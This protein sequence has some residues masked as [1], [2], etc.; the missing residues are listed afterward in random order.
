MPDPLAK[1]RRYNPKPLE[2]A[3]LVIVLSCLVLLAA[4][5]IGLLAR[6]ESDRANSSAYRGST[7]SRNL[8]EYAISVVMAQISSATK[9]DP[10]LAWASQPGAIRTYSAT[11]TDLVNIYKLY[12]SP[13]MV[14][15]TFP[16]DDTDF[17]G[18]ADNPALYTDLNAPVVTGSGANTRTNYPI[19]DPRASPA[20]RGFEIRRAPD[21][22]TLQPAPMPVTW[23]YVL[24]D[25]S[26]AAPTDDGNGNSVTVSAS[27]TN[28][29]VG[30]IAFWTDDDT[31]KVNINTASGA[32]WEYTNASFDVS[33]SLTPSTMMPANFWDTPIIGSRQDV[34]LAMSQPWA[35]EY[36]RFPGHPATVS[37]SAVFPNLTTNQIMDIAPRI[38]YQGG[39]SRWGSVLNPGA[40]RL[41]DDAARL[42]ANVDELLFATNR[43][44]SGTNPMTQQQLDQGRFFLT[45]SSRSPDVTLFNTPRLLIWPVDTAANKQ[46]P[47]DKLIA[48]CGTV[49]THSYYFQRTDAYSPTRDYNQPRNQTLLAYLRRMTTQA[50]P[51]FGGAS[52]ILGKYNASAPGESEQITTQ[53][54]DYIRCIN[55][56]DTSMN[57]P[58]N[59]VAQNAANYY[60]TNGLVVPTAG[61]N[62]TRGF[63]RFPMVS[64]VGLIFWYNAAGAGTTN[65]LCSRLLLETFIPGQGYPR[66][67]PPVPNFSIEVSGLT[68]G[69]GFQWGSD[70]ASMTNIFPSDSATY[71]S[72]VAFLASR[73]YGGRQSIS[74]LSGGAISAASPL[75][76]TSA[77]AT[78]DLTGGNITIRIIYGGHTIQ[79]INNISLPSVAGLPLP[80]TT[81]I[82]NNNGTSTICDGPQA[83]TDTSIRA[84]ASANVL[85]LPN[86][87]VR[88]VQVASGD[89]RMVAAGSNPLNGAAY[90][91]N[92]LNYFDTSTNSQTK[93]HSFLQAG[94]FPYQGSTMLAGGYYSPS[95]TNTFSADTARQVWVNGD[96]ITTG[97]TASGDFDN[98]YGEAGDGPYIGFADEGIQVNT[99]YENS[100]IPYLAQGSQTAVVGPGLYS[101]NR[102]VPSAGILGSLPTGVLANRP[103]QTLLFRPV[104][105]TV[106]GHPGAD[107]PPDYL[108]LDLFNMP[109]VEPYAIS[110]PL[111]TAGRVNMNYQILPFTYIQR[112]TAVQAALHTEWMTAIRSALA[113]NPASVASRT[114]KTAVL[115]T[116]TANNSRYPLNLT[117]TLKGFENRFAANDLFR[118][119]AEICSIPLVPTGSTWDA[120]NNG[121]FWSTNTLTGDNSKERAYAR[122]FPKLTTKSNTYTVHYRVEVLKK[123]PNSNAAT[124]IEGQDKVISTHRGS[125]TI[126]RYVTPG[127]PA[128]PDYASMATIPPTGTTALPNFYKF[129]VVGELQFNP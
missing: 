73:H 92:H 107:N 13:T 4:L 119:A 77:P 61:I 53:I 64:K 42:Y 89:F 68:S 120:V 103:W 99:T 10:T 69:G 35:G 90:F 127:D 88:S 28:P 87:V 39:G 30:R 55:L 12:S 81:T 101:P 44:V 24:E 128:M 16:S 115:T 49:G 40:A 22:T 108:L 102:L 83:W 109:V 76:S 45:A 17:T 59:T 71:K 85:I 46:T 117:E 105:L 66:I 129:R 70:A 58:T 18:W 11:G 15:D 104:A 112:S 36:Q 78:F 82:T 79:T 31:S 43:S 124:W 56:Q 32:P 84:R 106:A 125:T 86:D 51:G 48:F 98:G 20:V 126:E 122:I 116:G 114:R 5:V 6:V 34:N 65:T 3:A 95:D 72:Q 80:R 94:G 123:K 110:E 121:T 2:G 14:T 91:T 113:T 38:N 50:V 93:A 100:M 25:G 27:P 21:A 26:L 67:N 8:A 1:P 62:G 47:F 54:F 97:L 41:P 23:L 57:K 52:G 29:I 96:M 111:S 75:F 19:L 37:L 74:A 60:S 63:G 9:G 118:S 7:L 33:T